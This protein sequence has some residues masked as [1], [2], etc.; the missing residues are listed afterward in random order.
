MLKLSK[1]A[2]YAL[3]ALRHLATRRGQ[4]PCSAKEMAQAYGIPLELLAKVLQKLVKKGLLTSQHGAEGGYSLA[5]S[6]SAMTA[7]DV[8]HAIDGPLLITSC[9]TARGECFQAPKCTVR[10][11][12]GKVNEIIMEAL[13]SLTIAGL[14]SEGPGLVQIGE[15]AE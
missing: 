5:Q 11:P 13:N 7:F 10:E 1:K 15:A 6:P 8:I 3:I 12:L 9:V 2:D 14:G 4:H